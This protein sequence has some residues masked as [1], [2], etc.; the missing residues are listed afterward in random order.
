MARIKS[1]LGYSAAVL[2]ILVAVALPF[3]LMEAVT[4]GVAAT[5]IKVSPYY[6]GGAVA[7]TIQRDG[8]RI[9]VHQPFFPALFG[10]G[11]EGFVQLT[12]RPAPSLPSVVSEEI[13]LDRDGPPDMDIRFSTQPDAAG[14]LH[15]T[16]RPKS[17][18]VLPLEDATT[19]RDT[20]PMILPVKGTIV[21][22]VPL[23]NP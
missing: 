10:R 9:D 15:L 14:A 8:Y 20:W 12:F 22:R 23:V 4:R 7:R 18:R 16:V 17:R 3:K 2:T 5:G 1:Y 13:A 21:V 19:G 6:V 11:E